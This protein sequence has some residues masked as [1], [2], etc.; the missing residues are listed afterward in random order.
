M[1]TP[2]APKASVPATSFYFQSWLKLYLA[3]VIAYLPFICKFLWGN[4]DWIWLK[5]NTPLFS[6]VFEGRFSQFILPNLLFDGNILPIFTLLTS[7][8]FFTA[9]AILLFRL[10][11][12]PEK[13]CLYILLGLYLVSA[14]YTLS[15]LYFAF[16]TLSCLS[17][18]FVIAL[19][20]TLLNIPTL[21]TKKILYSLAAALLF[22]LALGG[23]PPVIN[24]IGVIFFTLII[25]NLCLK[26]L[27]A[28]TILRK[29][30]PNVLSLLGSGCLFFLILCALKKY[31][32][33]NE[34]YNTA[35]TSF[36]E[37]P[38]KLFL[39]LKA[40]FSQFFTTTSFISAGYKYLGLCIFLLALCNLWAKLPKRPSSVLLFIFSVIGLLLSTTLTLFAAGNTVYVLNEPRIE[41]FGLLYIYVYAAAILFCSSEGLNRNIILFV[42]SALIFANIKTI[43]CAAKIWTAGFNAEMSMT[44]R[45]IG[46]LEE[47]P[48]F[49]PAQ[50]YTFIQ[51]G[52]LDF[53]SRYASDDTS[54]KQDVYTLSAPYIS[55]HLPSKAY[56]FYSPYD[57]VSNDFDVYWS[58]IDSQSVPLT[59]GLQQYISRQA[60]PWPSSSALYVAPNIIILTLTADGKARAQNWLNHRTTP[61]PLS[62]PQN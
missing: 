59:P 7:L 25:N 32:L 41:F 23:Y 48:Q 31:G 58:Y 2:A 56:L 60:S 52:T 38:A 18:V 37:V 46:R 28:A 29:H 21:K 35:G 8:A 3:A 17:W 16:I 49:S 50:K 20:Y 9:A 1:P 57:F 62:L 34:T 53:R 6:G 4:H 55:W 39:C 42:I 13:S 43:S 22:A 12:I 11:Q 45:I 33:L 36:T 26:S 15:W 14:P 47:Q 44:E 30:L 51:G 10:W 19:A 5:E 54:E 24:L 27:T 61:Y 40:S